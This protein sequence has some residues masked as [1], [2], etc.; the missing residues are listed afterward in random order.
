M[1]KAAGTSA[2]A[3]GYQ[4]MAL[5]GPSLTMLV[6][7]LKTHF[8][9]RMS[10]WANAAILTSWGA[11]LLLHP[12][13]FDYPGLGIIFAKMKAMVWVDMAPE[14]VWGFVAF[15]V[16]SIRLM[17][18]FING[19]YSRTPLI[20]LG[21]AAVSAFVWTQVVIGLFAVPNTGLVVYPWLVVIDLIAAYRAGMDAALAEKRR[22]DV[23]LGIASVSSI[24]S[25]AVG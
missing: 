14:A 3:Q 19:A 16:G 22:K 10:E 13:L 15:V 24:G 11:Y 6:M 20:R 25:R 21:T 1:S 23:R 4:G 18:L 7:N 12:G 8:P 9:A 5:E 2:G 17:A